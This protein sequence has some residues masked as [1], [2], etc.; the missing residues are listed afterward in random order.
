MKEYFIKTGK[1]NFL[2]T[3]N[4]TH[5]QGYFGPGHKIG[6][7]IYKN[8]NAAKKASTRFFNGRVKEM[9]I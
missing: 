9:R 3:D 7:K 1:E 5:I 6:V 2:C 8:F 4:E